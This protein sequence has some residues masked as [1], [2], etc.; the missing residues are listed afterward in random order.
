MPQGTAVSQQAKISREFSARLEHIKPKQKVRAIILLQGQ[1][2]GSAATQPRSRLARQDTI[3]TIR[4]S[5]EQALRAIDRILKRFDGKRLADANTLGSV[6]VETTTEGISALA[7][8]DDVKA[9][10]EDQPISLLAK[11]GA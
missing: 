4:Q 7:D 3:S 6:P 10:L 11:V 2:T 1:Q 9:I 5:S 8:L